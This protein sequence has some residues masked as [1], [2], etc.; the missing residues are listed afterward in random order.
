MGILNG[1]NNREPF[2]SFDDFRSNS[3]TRRATQHRRQK[4]RNFVEPPRL[5]LSSMRVKEGGAVT[6]IRS[7][8]QRAFEERVTRTVRA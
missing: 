7:R 3:K 6:C 4:V 2:R 8:V 5:S 1:R